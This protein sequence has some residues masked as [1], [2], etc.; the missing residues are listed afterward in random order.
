MIINYKGKKLITTVYQ[1]MSDEVFN[2]I[3]KEFY[4]KPSLSQVKQEIHD[5]LFRG[6]SKTPSITRYFFRDLMAQVKLYNSKWS[7]ADAFEYKPILEHFYGRVCS[8]PKAFPPSKPLIENICAAFRI[9]GKGIVKMPTNFEIKL[10]K[11]ILGRYRLNNNYLDTSCGWGIRLLGSL[12]VNMKYFGIDPN[13]ILV[14]RLYQLYYLCKDIKTNIPSVD[15]RCQGSEIFIPEWE[16]KMGI[17]FTSPP[18]FDFEDYKIGDQSIKL[19]KTFR[20]WINKFWRPTIVNIYRY[21]I[22]NAYMIINIKD[23]KQ[24]K[25][26]ELTIEIASETGFK[27]WG[28]LKYIGNKRCHPKRDAISPILKI[29]LFRK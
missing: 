25:L 21:L 13:Y 23:Y 29:F 20:E 28:M 19:Y 24:Y 11:E 8:N 6:K 5:I 26:E 14:D 7:V 18:Y 12:S 16:N 3:K 4:K 10:V 17:S 2:T 27:Y 15:I 9:G 1:S 22:N